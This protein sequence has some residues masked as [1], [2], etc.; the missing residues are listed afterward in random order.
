V[1]RVLDFAF[2]LSLVCAFLATPFLLVNGVRFIAKQRRAGRGAP[3]TGLPIK[4]ILFFAVSC[5][6]GIV[7]GVTAT[8]LVKRTTLAFLKQQSDHLQVYVNERPAS[9]GAPIVETLRG[10][11]SYHA[12][13][14]HAT[15]RIRVEIRGPQTSLVLDLGRDSDLPN[16][17]WVF[18]PVSFITSSNEIGKIRTALFD[19][20]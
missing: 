2:G 19:R 5:L 8:T 1:L 20:Y 9:N 6:L 18:S 15:T 11:R 13:H 14:S 4:S 17:Y 16:E 12:H 7:T 10:L 3:I